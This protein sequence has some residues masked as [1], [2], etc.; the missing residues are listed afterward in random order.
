M[1]KLQTGKIK[2]GAKLSEESTEKTMCPKYYFIIFANHC[3]K[4]LT[5]FYNFN[6]KSFKQ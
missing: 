4:N 3:G 6:M 1:E 2:E 5:A